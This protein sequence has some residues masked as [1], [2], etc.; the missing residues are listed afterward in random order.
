MNIS[1]VIAAVASGMVFVT[2]GQTASAATSLT[3]GSGIS[4]INGAS[5]G[6]PVPARSMEGNETDGANEAGAVTAN[7]YFQFTITPTVGNT[8]SLTQISLDFAASFNTQPRGF[9]LRS[10]L[11]GYAN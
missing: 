5:V 8:M 3:D 10:N 11:D 2:S 7:D 4:S 6:N 9:A 1:P